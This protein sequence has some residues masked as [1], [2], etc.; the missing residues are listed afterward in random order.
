MAFFDSFGARFFRVTVEYCMGQQ[1]SSQKPH[2]H[3]SSSA[4]LSPEMTPEKRK[5]RNRHSHLASTPQPTDYDS[6]PPA[7]A[8]PSKPHPSTTTS[9]TRTN[10][11]LNLSVL[12]RHLPSTTSILLIAPY[13]V[14]YTF[15][16]DTSSW[17][18]SGIE[19]T[20]FICA[21]T[22]RPDTGGRR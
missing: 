5:A 13:A 14:I 19:G 11:Q 21:Q 16:P 10:P 17:E 3:V 2:K 12:Q 9:T 18:K 6:D 4:P 22:P 8:I 15:I 1:F 7:I 20:L